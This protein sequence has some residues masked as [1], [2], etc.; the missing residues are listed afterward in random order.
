[1]PLKIPTLTEAIAREQIAEVGEA[2]GQGKR[3]SDDVGEEAFEV[4]KPVDHLLFPV[5]I[6]KNSGT[7]DLPASAGNAHPN[8]AGAAC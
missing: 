8:G 6:S 7:R 5:G 2:R 3:V 4:E 1:V